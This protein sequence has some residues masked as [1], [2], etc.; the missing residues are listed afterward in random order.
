M[1]N[2]GL[3]PSSRSP[4]KPMKAMPLSTVSRL[5]D[6]HLNSRVSL[7]KDALQ[8]QLRLLF[9]S[10]RALSLLGF[11]KWPEAFV[12][13]TSLR[14]SYF[15]AVVPPEIPFHERRKKVLSPHQLKPLPN[16]MTHFGQTDVKPRKW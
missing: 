1:F 7:I 13:P 15:S 10:E 6:G 2:S 3:N 14:M 11:S 5:P 9:R 12:G 8:E 16:N 4:D